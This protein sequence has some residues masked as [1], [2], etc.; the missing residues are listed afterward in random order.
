MVIRKVKGIIVFKLEVALSEVIFLVEEAIEGGYIAR[1]LG[2]SIY[3]E[4]EK[5]GE[6]KSA[7]QE[8]VNCHFEE[9]QRPSLVRMHLN[10]DGVFVL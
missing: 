9:D 3:T 8:A 4:A 1:A 2:H 7:I 10:R 6:L 5:W